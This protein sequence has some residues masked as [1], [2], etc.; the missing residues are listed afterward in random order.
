MNLGQPR[1]RYLLFQPNYQE[2]I[3][4]SW[5]PKGCYCY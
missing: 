5:P 1:L 3:L 2:H 4:A